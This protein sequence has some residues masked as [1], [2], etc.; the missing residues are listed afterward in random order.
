MS[1]ALKAYRWINAWATLVY[2]G[3]SLVGGVMIFPPRKSGYTG[4]YHC[5]CGIDDLALDAFCY[6][7]AMDDPKQC[8]HL[9]Q[10]P[11][12]PLEDELVKRRKTGWKKRRRAKHPPIRVT[13]GRHPR[14]GQFEF[15]SQDDSYLVKFRIG[16]KGKSRSAT[17]CDICDREELADDRLRLGWLIAD[18]YE[19]DGL[20]LLDAIPGPNEAMREYTRLSNVASEWRRWAIG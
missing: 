14:L 16:P 18:M 2:T 1:D 13:E 5:G 19:L 9:S 6:N 8:S 4:I 15:Q 11:P 3:F 12:L 7:L 17:L 20:H 10:L